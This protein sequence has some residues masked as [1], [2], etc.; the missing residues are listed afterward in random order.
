MLY[1]AAPYGGQPPHGVV[2]A[3]LSL[4]EVDAAVHALKSGDKVF[5]GDKVETGPDGQLQVLLL[6]QTV[7]TLGPLSA[8][9][10]DE[11]I[12]D[13]KTDDGKVKA[14]MLKGIF[15]V[16]SGKIAHNGIGK[17]VAVHIANGHRTV[18]RMFESDKVTAV[19]FPCRA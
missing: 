6:D 11:F 3:A 2:R 12:Y 17:A 8:V 1:L 15:R 18:N 14:S 19:F 13:P 16:V 7:F 5:M 9:K 10:V 4:Q